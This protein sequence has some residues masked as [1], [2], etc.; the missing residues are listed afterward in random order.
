MTINGHCSDFGGNLRADY[1]PSRQ[2]F[3]KQFPIDRGRS[4]AA[5]SNRHLSAMRLTFCELPQLLC[6]AQHINAKML[7]LNNEGMD[8]YRD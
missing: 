5:L 4:I 1:Q 8:W 6:R 2:A 7:G 3:Q